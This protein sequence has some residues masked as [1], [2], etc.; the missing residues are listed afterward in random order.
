MR[1]SKVNEIIKLLFLFFERNVLNIGLLKK[2]SF[3]IFLVGVILAFTAF[4]SFELYYFFESTDSSIAQTSVVI[5]SYSCS[6]FMWTFLV[7]IFVKILFMKKG[8]LLEF[9]TQMPVSRREKNLAVLVFEIVTALGLVLFFSSS[10]IIALVIRNGVFFLPRIICNILFQCVTIYFLFELVYS[11]LGLLC[12]WFGLGKV[13]NIIIICIMSLL[14]VC[15][16]VVVIPDVFLSILYTY[17]D[18]TGTA[19]IL[20]YVVV[21]E[22]YG[23]GVATLLFTMI[24]TLLGVTII[25]IPN[26]EV[27]YNNKYIRIARKVIGKNTMFGAYID[28]FFRKADTINYYFIALFIFCMTIVMKVEYGYY[29]ILIL[30]LN[31]LYGFVQTDELRYIAMQRKYSVFKDYMLLIA[32]QVYYISLLAMPICLFNGIYTRD[33]N[34]VGGLML[35]IIFSVIFFSMAGIFFP[36]RNENPFSAM[37]GIVFVLVVGI[38]AVAVCFFLKLS[39]IK[40]IFFITLLIIVSVLSSIQGLKK[41]YFK[42]L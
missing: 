10:M 4:L 15:F 3:R 31:S 6:V 5:D 34:F 42:R 27:E 2:K 16:Y 11:V 23:L 30:S 41:L 28:A 17:K 38:L 20:F 21:T 22:K 1:F 35:A 12:S 8:N 36:A 25:N 26:N 14:L 24:I 18:Q 19:N 9:A 37:F 29:A 13:K 33:I 40:T 39:V 7:F 32:S